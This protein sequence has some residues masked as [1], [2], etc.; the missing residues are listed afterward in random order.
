MPTNR[1]QK[2]GT[3]RIVETRTMIADLE[4][5]GVDEIAATIRGN[6]NETTR[7][8]KR[9]M[10][11]IVKRRVDDGVNGATYTPRYAAIKNIIKGGGY[12]SRGPVDLNLSGNLMKNLVGRG[13]ARPAQGSIRIWLDFKNNSRPRTVRSR[14]GKPYRSTT[15]NRQLMDII[16][17]EIRVS[18]PGFPKLDN[19]GNP[20]IGLHGDETSQ[21]IHETVRT[22]MRKS[23]AE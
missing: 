21:L 16:N 11:A 9:K 14:N 19:E 3:Q 4:G 18:N 8:A 13:R 15:T 2:G 17:G 10:A 6:M 7:I 1:R 23:G 20:P 22:L 5:G 12:S